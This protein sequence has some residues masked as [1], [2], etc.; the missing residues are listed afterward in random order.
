MV[1][2]QLCDNRVY[3]AAMTSTPRIRRSQAARRATTRSALM[4]SA[5]TLFGRDG[6]AATGLD[7][8]A[9]VAGVTKGALYHHFAN[10]RELFH[11]VCEEW[12]DEQYSA[13]RTVKGRGARALMARIDVFLDYCA[14]PG[15]RQVVLLDSPT[16]LGLARWDEPAVRRGGQHI[17]LDL[18]E[19]LPEL[20]AP[21]RAMAGRMLIGALIEAAKAMASAEAREADRV[22]AQVRTV[23]A[24]LINAAAAP[25][26]A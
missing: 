11:A 17:D 5:R 22:R 14:D 12:E 10:K 16:V 18:E 7:T 21:T 9:A 2:R 1:R 15:Y 23:L 8:V 19:L 13:M 24:R 6:Y 4:T 26:G 3:F 25:G 20:D